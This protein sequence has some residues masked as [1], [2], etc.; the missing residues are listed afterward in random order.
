MSNPFLPP[1]DDDDAAWSAYM[2]EWA[3]QTPPDYHTPFANFERA[4]IAGRLLR[5]I[6]GIAD[7][8]VPGD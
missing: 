2:Q 5:S 3:K 4:L 1:D 8:E 6:P 7:R